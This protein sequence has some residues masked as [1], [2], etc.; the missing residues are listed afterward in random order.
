MKI[1]WERVVIAAF[2]LE[3]VL[4]ATLI[5]IQLAFGMR[6]FLIAVPIGVFVES[7]LITRWSL[8]RVQFR[9]L[10]HGLLI[11]L[12][13]TLFYF[14]LV[15]A[16]SGSVQPVIDTYGPFWAVFGNLLRIAGALLG[17]ATV[18]SR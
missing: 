11:G 18:R 1:H 13:A 8:R 7:F 5:P 12:I 6:A 10:L 17:A 4:F 2:V 3:L 9:T 16:T 15:L 14:G